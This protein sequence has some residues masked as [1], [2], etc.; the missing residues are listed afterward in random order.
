MYR[1]MCI[2]LQEIPE[3][4]LSWQWDLPR[5]LLSDASLGEVDALQGL[6]S[7]VRWQGGI[8]RTGDLYMLDGTWELSLKRECSRCNAEFVATMRGSSRRD[9]RVG[10]RITAND[11]E[12]EGDVLPPPGAVDL[13][14][15]L[16]ESVWLSWNQVAV[17]SETC[18]GLCSRC[19]EDLNRGACRCSG[20]DDDHPFAALQQLKFD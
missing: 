16:R 12:L 13:L 8:T 7:D 1:Q 11:E 5:T 6:C 2:R 17:C 14:D 18:K 3:T 20:V 15:V 19:G 4:G 9:F 10:G